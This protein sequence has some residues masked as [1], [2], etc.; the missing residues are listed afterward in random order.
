MVITE[1]GVYV[2]DRSWQ[3]LSPTLDGSII[4][5]ANDVMLDLQGFELLGDSGVKSDG[6]NV[7]IRNGRL[8][9]RSG[10]AIEATGE[11]TVVDR[12]VV[13]VDPAVGGL[14][15]R[16]VS[17]HRHRS[18]LVNSDISVREAL[19]VNAGDDT[20]VRDNRIESDWVPIRTATRTWV[21]GNDVQC[22][23]ACVLVDGTDNVISHNKMT[24]TM[25]VGTEGVTIFGNNNHVEDNV[26]LTHCIGS[27]ATFGRAISVE[28][29]GNTV[30]DNLV[31]AGCAGTSWWASGITFHRDGNFYGD[32]IVWAG[33]P[34]NVGATVQTDL[35]GNVG[36][37]N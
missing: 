18:T 36:F 3:V 22:G 16:G 4:I 5:D 25:V 14:N 35:G 19:A 32:N 10:F 20:I 6:E 23:R 33:S 17:L 24:E 31:P 28:G 15:S 8:I 2:L 9:V 7:T 1:P 34:F 29:Q 27:G 13:R 21:T 37:S 30:R 12:I 26:F 11:G